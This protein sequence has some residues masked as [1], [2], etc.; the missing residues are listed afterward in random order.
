MTTPSNLSPEEFAAQYPEAQKMIDELEHA[1]E[2]IFGESYDEH[3]SRLAA[4][5]AEHGGSP[6]W[7]ANADL[8]D[9]VN[10][11]NWESA[12]GGKYKGK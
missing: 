3:K 10:M 11:S 5:V 6:R 9:D 8:C 1:Y 4:F 2:V 12:N 7:W